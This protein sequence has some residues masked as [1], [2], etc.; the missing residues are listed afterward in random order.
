MKTI[1]RT[2]MSAVTLAAAAVS[3]WYA[4][5]AIWGWLTH[6]QALALGLLT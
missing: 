3:G 2:A 4:A 5:P 6:L 1:A